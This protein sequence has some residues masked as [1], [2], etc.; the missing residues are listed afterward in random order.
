MEAE[1]LHR[2]STPIPSPAP[3]NNSS[4]VTSLSVMRAPLSNVTTDL[5]VPAQGLTLPFTLATPQIVLQKRKNFKFRRV[6]DFETVNID[7]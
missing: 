5:D 2:T 6:D 4:C 1:D 7:Q 3:D